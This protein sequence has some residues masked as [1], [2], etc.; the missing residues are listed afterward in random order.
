LER[1]ASGRFVVESLAQRFWKYAR[2]T[3]GCWPWAGEW[4]THGYGM[5]RVLVVENGRRRRRWL[6]AHRVSWELAHGPIPAGLGVLHRCDNP[7]CVNP[8]HLFLGTHKDNMA[9][10]SRKGRSRGGETH[11]EDSHLA[12]LTAAQVIE[13]LD[14]L[15]NGESQASLAD[16]YGV[17]RQAIWQI[18]K[19]RCWKRLQAARTAA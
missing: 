16:E 11:G 15:A 7:P 13:I 8:V 18:G 4:S 10:C 3:D 12:K 14:R 19:G 5:I 1:D 9:D 2:K 6:A 17:T